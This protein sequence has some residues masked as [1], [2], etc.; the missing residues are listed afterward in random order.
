MVVLCNALCALRRR[1]CRGFNGG[2][3]DVVY[4]VVANT[5]MKIDVAAG[6][7]KRAGT[8]ALRKAGVEGKVWAKGYG[9]DFC[10]D[11]DS[12]ATRIAYVERHGEE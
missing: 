10:F 11:S 4:V 5:A 12:V 2:R 7:Y 9:K 3:Y 8:L 6:R 1:R